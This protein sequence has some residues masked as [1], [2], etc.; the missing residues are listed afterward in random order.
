MEKM[1]FLS[2]DLVKVWA[3]QSFFGGGFIKGRLA[4]VKQNVMQNDSSVLVIV[5][6]KFDINSEDRIERVEGID[7][8]Y[9][10]YCQQVEFVRHATKDELEHMTHYIKLNQYIV[11]HE[12]QMWLKHGDGKPPSDHCDHYAPKLYFDED[13]LLRVDAT[14]LKY[15]ENFI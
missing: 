15:P 6:R 5:R 4:R 11:E 14:M 7:L 1:K 8:S 9:E 2:G 13:V 12:Q 10:V 3:L